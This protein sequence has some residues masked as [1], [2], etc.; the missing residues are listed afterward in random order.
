MS[1]G[2]C[3]KWAW[4]AS[5]ERTLSGTGARVYTAHSGWLGV[6]DGYAASTGSVLVLLD[7]SFPGDWY[8]TSAP[9]KEIK[10]RRVHAA[11]ARTYAC[12]RVAK[13]TRRWCKLLPVEESL[14]PRDEV[15][16]GSDVEMC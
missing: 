6:V 3:W 4:S 9:Y 13:C 1:A 10:R 12:L 5:Q 2:A 16:A 7:V 11:R 14:R 8:F 15:G